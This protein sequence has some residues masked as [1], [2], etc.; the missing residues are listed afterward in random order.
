MKLILGSYEAYVTG[1]VSFATRGSQAEHLHFIF[2]IYI[3]L[4]AGVFVAFPN[5]GP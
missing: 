5:F 3:R 2:K 1:V 4:G